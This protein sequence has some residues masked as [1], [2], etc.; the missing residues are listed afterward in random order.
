MQLAKDHSFTSKARLSYRI[1]LSTQ[2]KQNR[3][4]GRVAFDNHVTVVGRGSHLPTPHGIIMIQSRRRRLMQSG[5]HCMVSY[6]GG[7]VNGPH[8]IAFNF[9]NYDCHRIETGNVEG[10]SV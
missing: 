7:S 2:Y 9:N 6:D 3:G 1:K 8:C 10:H 5:Q 4:E